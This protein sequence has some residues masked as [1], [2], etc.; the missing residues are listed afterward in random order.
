M[1]DSPVTEGQVL[2]GK[3]R[4]ERVLGSGGMGVV[5]AAWHL[6]LEQ[7]VAV[8]FLHPLALERADTAERFRREARSAAKIRSEHV[9]RVI[10]VGIMEGGIPYMVME[11]LEGHDVAAEMAKVGPLPIE[12]AVDFVLQAVEA[13]AEAHAAGIVHRDLK[14]ANLFIASRADGSRIVKVLD[15]GISKSLL[16]NSASELSLTR[17]S[18]L[19]GSPLYMSPEQMRSAKDVDTRTDVWSLGVIL[20]EMIT[21]RPPYTG[22]SIPALCASL[23]NDV[24]QSMRSLRPDVPPELEDVIS[25]CLAKD[26]ADRYTTVSELA[27]ALAQF[28]SVSSLLHVDRAS[29]VLGVTEV[30]GLS[31]SSD[32][33]LSRSAD[34]SGQ[35]R[36]V[37]V[38]R[39]TPVRATV[40]SWGR[41]DSPLTG[42]TNTPKPKSRGLIFAALG[43]G[44]AGAAGVVFFLGSRSPG[45]PPSA[46]AS[47]A[48]PSPPMHTT[49]AVVIPPA[50]APAPAPVP[51]VPEPVVLPSAAA[52]DPSAPVVR[53]QEPALKPKPVVQAPAVVFKPKPAPAK[54]TTAGDLSDFGGRR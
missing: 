24:P 23:L 49:A 8:K 52:P 7:R 39:I 18:V 44:I 20:Y 22:D 33:R 35:A 50:P 54:A 47:V 17:T 10:D 9:A 15:F 13:L 19:I 53:P 41:T 4:V 46:S 36:A 12:D 21:G 3:Y 30:S 37:S 38:Q 25:H 40:D 11:Y 14:P 28:G 43:I 6:E 51:V 34:A 45:A 2:A 26:R 31:D 1:A 29:R 32:R 48:T 5:V 16:G 42:D 27:R